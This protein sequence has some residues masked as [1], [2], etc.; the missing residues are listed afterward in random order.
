ML[1]PGLK[2]GGPVCDSRKSASLNRRHYGASRRTATGG[3]GADSRESAVPFNI[4]AVLFAGAPVL[5]STTGA[6]PPQVTAN[7]VLPVLRPVDQQRI[8]ARLRLTLHASTTA[9]TARLKS[10]S[11][12]KAR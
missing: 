12:D 7:A 5:V 9:C 8:S 3:P 2:S 11:R 6:E 4:I 10:G 1:K